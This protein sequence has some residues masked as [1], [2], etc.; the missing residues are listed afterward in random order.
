MGNEGVPPDK[1]RMGNEG[2]PPDKDRMGNERAPPDEDR[3]EKEQV[4][5]GK[6][7]MG[8]EQ[9]PPG[10][11]RTG[12]R[13][14]A[15]E[16]E[17]EKETTPSEETRKKEMELEPEDETEVGDESKR[18]REKEQQ[19]RRIRKQKQAAKRRL[20]GQEPHSADDDSQSGAAEG[21]EELSTAEANETPITAQ[22]S[23]HGAEPLADTLS[24][25]EDRGLSVGIG[26]GSTSAGP[27]HP[28]AAPS[29]EVMDE[30]AT[31]PTARSPADKGADSMP[32]TPSREEP[33]TGLSL[34]PRQLRERRWDGTV[35][36][37]KTRDP[38]FFR[39][40]GGPL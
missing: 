37:P 2:V 27:P 17:P 35:V 25:S 10:K 15:M 33:P 19:R 29:A 14:K 34:S 28:P 30:G 5:P 38:R 32:E 16:M 26:C 24:L 36:P 23:P 21:V 40:G 13:R 39:T 9:V 12:N 20:S 7:R 31:P 1:D 4:P 3:V 11:D 8:K 18:K 6:D 22:A